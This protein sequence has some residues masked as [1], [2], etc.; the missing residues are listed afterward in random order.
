MCGKVQVVQNGTNITNH[1]H[2][3]SRLR[4]NS[5]TACYY[6]VQHTH[7][8]S[9][10]LSRN[11]NIKLYNVYVYLL[12]FMVLKLDLTMREENVQEQV[13]ESNIWT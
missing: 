8:S 11:L 1:I 13:T 4:L 12:Y 7:L 3:S 10:V 2:R 6:S 5:R 9:C